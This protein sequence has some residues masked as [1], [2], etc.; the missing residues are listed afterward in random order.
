MTHIRLFF[1]LIY[2][3]IRSNVYLWARNYCERYERSKPPLTIL[4]GGQEW[5]V[6][7][8]EDLLHTCGDCGQHLTIVRPGSYQCDNPHCPSLVENML[9]EAAEEGW[10]V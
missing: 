8:D 2:H 7:D 9:A 4:G 6:Y 10:P 5:K 3:G 1:S